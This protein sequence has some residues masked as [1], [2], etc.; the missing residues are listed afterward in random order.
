MP[1]DYRLHVDCAAAL[2]V[3]HDSPAVRC[4]R[5]LRIRWTVS[6][7]HRRALVD[8][9][10]SLDG[11]AVSPHPDQGKGRPARWHVRP[12]EWVEGFDIETEREGVRI[13]GA[14]IPPPRTRTPGAWF[15][16]ECG[17]WRRYLPG[18]TFAEEIRPKDYW[19]TSKYIPGQK[20]EI[21][22]PTDPDRARR[23]VTFD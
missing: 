7:Q 3:I 23:S 15:A 14:D 11:R 10:G 16:W 6:E 13:L 18:A 21:K 5:M 19:H 22:P 12:V 4:P 8:R 9:L 1:N 2:H 17:E 20:T